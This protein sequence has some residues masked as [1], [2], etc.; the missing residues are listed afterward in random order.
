MKMDFIK[1]S[2]H[3]LITC[4]DINVGIIKDGRL[5]SILWESGLDSHMLSKI[6]EHINKNT[7]FK[8]NDIVKIVPIDEW[9]LI[10][11][12]EDKSASLHVNGENH[13]YGFENLCGT[14][15]NY[16]VVKNDLRTH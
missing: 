13:V 10:Y 4:N 16:G 8:R 6:S 1:K 5:V 3:T 15:Y 7:D 11:W 14:R 2:D 9:G 12:I